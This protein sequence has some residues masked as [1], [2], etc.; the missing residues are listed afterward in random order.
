[1]KHRYVIMV[2]GLMFAACCFA[3]ESDQTPASRADVMT[4]FE[5]IHSHDMMDKLMNGMLKPMHEMIHDE[6]LRNQSKL[7]TDFEERMAKQ[8][9]DM[10]KKMPWDQIIDAMIPAYQKHFTKGDINA[11]LAFYSS[12]TGQKLLR[13]MPAIVSESMGSAMPILR[14]HIQEMQS[15]L[16]QQSKDMVD[17]SE[18]A[19]SEKATP[20][21]KN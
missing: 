13:D 7:P 15:K 6:Y 19:D 3:Q 10:Y 9:D 11:M 18:K 14:N 20:P 2:F 21:A 12:P 16:E 17:G 8:M 1:M 5:T 4:Y